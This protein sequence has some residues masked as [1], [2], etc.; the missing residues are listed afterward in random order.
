MSRILITGGAGFIGYHLARHMVDAG[1]DVIIVDNFERAVFDTDLARLSESPLCTIYNVDLT[2]DPLPDVHPDSLVHLAAIV[3]V[4]NVLSRPNDV[5]RSN[6]TSLMRILDQA[7]AMPDLQGLLFAST[8]EVYAGAVHEGLAVLPTPETTPLVILDS[9]DPRG[10]YLLSKIYGE[11][12]CLSSGLPVTIVRPHNVYGPR[13]GMSHVIPELLARCWSAEPG[14]ELEVASV[15]H[16]RSFCYIDDAIG[17][18]AALLGRPA[19]GEVLNLGRQEPEV[20]IGALAQVVID[21]VGKPLTVKT[22]PATI[23]SP[24]R[25]CPETRLL[26]SVTGYQPLVGL[27]EGVRRTFDWYRSQ[28]FSGV[29][30]SAR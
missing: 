18:L 22:L 25:R 10:T 17:I 27:E 4:R 15:D 9:A 3:G 24:S 16:T 7:A 6:V 29:D 2:A 20:T 5:L 1:H 11:A 13:M 14:D 8:S 21:T 19:T 12:L 28:V 30:E 23:G 26:T